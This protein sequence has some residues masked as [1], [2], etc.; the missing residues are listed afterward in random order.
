MIIAHRLADCSYC[1]ERSPQ[2]LEGQ[3]EAQ[4]HLSLLFPDRFWLVFVGYL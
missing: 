2:W 4:S 3:S 1:Q